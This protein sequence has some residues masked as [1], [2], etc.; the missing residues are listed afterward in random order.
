MTHAL[1]IMFFGGVFVLAGATLTTT[2]Y[3]HRREIA[4]ALMTE[5]RRRR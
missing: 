5:V 1:S 3:R 4:L 2:V